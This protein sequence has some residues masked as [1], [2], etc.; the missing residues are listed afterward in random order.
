MYGSDW[1]VSLLAGTYAETFAATDLLTA[2]LTPSER[3]A[4]FSGTAERVYRLPVGS[5]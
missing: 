2:H 1:P 5:T 4:L 3:T